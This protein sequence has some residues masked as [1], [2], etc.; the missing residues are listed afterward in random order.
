MN[1]GREL[2]QQVMLQTGSPVKHITK[3]AEVKQYK[4]KNKNP[5]LPSK[6][7]AQK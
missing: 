7:S 2:L 3:Q 5:Q 4:P 6:F 1:T